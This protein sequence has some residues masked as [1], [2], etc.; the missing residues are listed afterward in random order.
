M[1]CSMHC[2]LDFSKWLRLELDE[3]TSWT[4]TSINETPKWPAE[5]QQ[6]Q[7]QQQQQRQQQPAG[8]T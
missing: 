8:W 1:T 6:Q 3:K 7:Q 4:E 5:L 2:W